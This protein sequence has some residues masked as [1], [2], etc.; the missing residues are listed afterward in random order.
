MS[1][2]GCQSHGA[3][4]HVTFTIGVSSAETQKAP[5]VADSIA[6]QNVVREQHCGRL[7]WPLASKGTFQRPDLH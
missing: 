3:A 5:P 2:R 1:P 6:S 4:R 7:R